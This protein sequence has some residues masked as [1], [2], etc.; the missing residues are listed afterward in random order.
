MPHAATAA[1]TSWLHRP[2]LITRASIARSGDRLAGLAASSDTERVVR[3]AL[4][5]VPLVSG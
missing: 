2:A 4:A 3:V 1:G 5:D